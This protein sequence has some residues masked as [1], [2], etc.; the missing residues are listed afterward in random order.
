[1]VGG[2]RIT[3][4]IFPARMNPPHIGHI[5]TILN[6]REQYGKVIVAVI[7]DDFNGDKP[8]LISKEKVIEI[9]NDIFRHIGSIDVIDGGEP[10]RLRKSFNDLP[11]FDVVVS[12]SN[13]V[14]DNCRKRNLSCACCDRTP[15]YRGECIREAY[16]NGVERE[17]VKRH[18]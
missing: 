10:F 7:N 14:L 11:E 8:N 17:A 6:L 5:T 18:A 13:D 12:G 1:M 15:V 3:T 16:R 2:G 4:V 9:T